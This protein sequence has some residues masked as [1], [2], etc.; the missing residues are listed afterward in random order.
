VIVIS[1]GVLNFNIDKEVSEFDNHLKCAVPVV[2]ILDDYSHS[3]YPFFNVEE[4]TIVKEI[5]K[6]SFN[7]HIPFHLNLRL[8]GESSDYV[9]VDFRCPNNYV[10]LK[11]NKGRNTL[12][13]EAQEQIYCDNNTGYKAI[14]RAFIDNMQKDFHLIQG[15]DDSEIKDKYNLFWAENQK[16]FS[17]IID[18]D[19]MIFE[20]HNKK[21]N[22]F[23]GWTGG[24][25]P[26]ERY[27]AKIL[28]QALENQKKAFE[29]TDK[30]QSLEKRIN[31]LKMLFDNIKKISKMKQVNKDKNYTSCG[32]ILLE[33]MLPE[34]AFKFE[35]TL[36]SK[37]Y[38]F[39]R[40]FSSDLKNRLNLEKNIESRILVDQGDYPSTIFYDN[41]SGTA[42]H[43]EKIDFGDQ[44]FHCELYVPLKNAK[45]NEENLKHNAD[46]DIF[47][48]HADD[49]TPQ[50][51]ATTFEYVG[52]ENDI[53]SAL[54]RCLEKL[55]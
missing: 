50:K 9:Q 52:S 41:I 49:M 3:K 25:Y 44:K 54:E 48:I 39:A 35:N 26:S 19:V 36:R 1:N 30:I 15:F 14:I 23:R 51:L 38:S 7:M 11:H 12:H 42:F 40:K 31:T 17:T 29:S 47:I 43:I 24:Y 32:K 20:D 21:H 27:P 34:Y 2:S 45:C 10:Q 8:E 46:K 13:V 6:K 16:Y 18:D 4:P 22:V 55:I 28:T 53:P 5:S 33:D 37:E